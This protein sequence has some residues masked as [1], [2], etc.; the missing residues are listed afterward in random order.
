MEEVVKTTLLDVLVARKKL[1]FEIAKRIIDFVAFTCGVCGVA[2]NETLWVV[3][4]K[5][6]Q[7]AP[8]F[9]KKCVAARTGFRSRRRIVG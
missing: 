4:E 2:L 8:C 6:T 3:A 9:E 5:N 7:C 1:P